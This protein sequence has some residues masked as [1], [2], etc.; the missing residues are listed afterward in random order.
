MTF[1][2]ICVAVLAAGQSRRMGF[3]KLVAPF[4][5]TTLL[6]R[7]LDA[8]LGCASD[9]VC[10]VTGA[11]RDQM[12]PML[13]RRGAVEWAQVQQGTPGSWPTEG[14][15]RLAAVHNARWR[16]GQA[17]SVQAAV[18]FARDCDCAAVLMLVADQPFVQ[19]RH[20]DAL[21]GEF[22]TGT[23]QAYLASTERGC[24]N[25]CLFDRALF[26]DLLALTGDEGARKLL[27]SRRDIAVRPVYFDE[28]SLLDDA[29]TPEE[30]A[31]LEEAVLHG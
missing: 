2:K 8:A 30:F 13:A 27:R 3:P 31:R 19:A 28:P 7:A 5:G 23:A 14:S 12:A 26:D 1:P 15:G 4:A 10:V 9:A 20:L 25:P 17:S 16:T 11:Y 29:D 22:K 18:R 6:D 24:G 21:I